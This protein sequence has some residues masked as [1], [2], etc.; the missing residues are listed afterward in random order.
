MLDMK[1]QIPRKISESKT[2]FK[3]N[4]RGQQ[5]RNQRLPEASKIPP[6]KKKIAKNEQ[7]QKRNNT[8]SVL[9]LQKG[10]LEKISNILGCLWLSPCLDIG[11]TFTLKELRSHT[12]KW[13]FFLIITFYLSTQETDVR[14]SLFGLFFLWQ[15]KWLPICR[16]VF[17]LDSA[18]VNHRQR[19]TLAAILF[20]TMSYGNGK[21]SSKHSHTIF[22]V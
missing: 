14:S 3:S 21:Q 18:H 12:L 19:C 8:T 6:P 10:G 2:H 11:I 4:Q 16:A 15:T 20:I 9:N 22:F 17:C 1:S 13:P 7:C 5:A